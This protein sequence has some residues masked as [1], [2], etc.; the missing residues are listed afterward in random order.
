MECRSGRFRGVDG[1]RFR[2]AGA[3]WPCS[4][5]HAGWYS[6][7]KHAGWYSPWKHTG[8]DSPGK[9]ADEYSPGEYTGWKRNG[10]QYV[11]LFIFHGRLGA[12][13]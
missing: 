1:C 2:T 13:R 6:P 7:W 8:G 12:V 11:Y 5:K 4:G 3:G 9:C 10:L